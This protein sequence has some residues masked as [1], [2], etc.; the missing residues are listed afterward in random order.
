MWEET[1]DRKYP[2][3]VQARELV[4]SF[5][6]AF[7]FHCS[8]IQSVCGRY[9]KQLGTQCV[10]TISKALQKPSFLS[11]ARSLMKDIQAPY[12]RTSRLQVWAL[13]SMPVTLPL[14]Q[15]GKATKCNNRCKGGGVMWSINLDAPSDTSPI[16]ILKVMRGSWNDCRQVRDVKLIPNGPLYVIDRGFYSMNTMIAWGEQLVRYIMRAKKQYLDYEVLETISKPRKLASGIRIELDARVIIRTKQSKQSVEVRLVKAWLDDGTDLFLVTTLY[17]ASAEHILKCYRRR[18]RIEKFHQLLK[19]TIG[20]A[21]LYS[22]EDTGIELLIEIAAMTAILLYLASGGRQAD[23]D[24]VRAIRRAFREIRRM[25][26]LGTPWKRNTFTPTRKR[27][28]PSNISKRRRLAM[29]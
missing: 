9:G 19:D 28:K 13:D 29:Q 20:L 16:R 26:D 7:L 27:A 24:T 12:K 17:S 15:R 21:H 3:T 2:R 18:D 25:L 14:T 6:G 4:L 10:S 11:F 8:S 5:V 1:E 23:E 22:F